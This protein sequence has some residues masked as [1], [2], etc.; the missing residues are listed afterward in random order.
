MKSASK[1]AVL[2]YQEGKGENEH[3]PENV[4]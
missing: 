3:N 2:K 4:A 1:Q